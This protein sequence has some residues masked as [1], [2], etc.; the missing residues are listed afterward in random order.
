MLQGG[1]G[2]RTGACG[3]NGL[4]RRESPRTRGGG[5]RKEP[6][7]QPTFLKGLG[8]DYWRSA[9]QGA[10]TASAPRGLPRQTWSTPASGQVRHGEEMAASGPGRAEL[11][12]RAAVG[13]GRGSWGR[14]AGQAG[15]ALLCIGRHRDEQPLPRLQATS[16]VSWSLPRP[17][18]LGVKFKHVQLVVS[19]TLT[20]DTAK[21]RRTGRGRG[22]AV[23]VEITS[24]E[25]QVSAPGTEAGAWSPW[26]KQGWCSGRHAAQGT[27]DSRAPITNTLT[28]QLIY[29]PRLEPR[30]P[31]VHTPELTCVPGGSLLQSYSELPGPRSQA[32]CPQNTN[33]ARFLPPAPAPQAHVGSRN[34]EAEVSGGLTRLSIHGEGHR[35]EE[36][37]SHRGGAAGQ[38]ELGGARQGPA[39]HLEGGGSR[40]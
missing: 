29:Q 36:A 35:D 17:L 25:D 37:E 13:R 31:P 20:P 26:Q 34:R 16:L 40:V 22:R 30:A 10:N 15:R 21:G 27:G 3:P 33:T 5:P 1:R 9:G 38:P 2:A 4:G 32:K 39:L 28:L 11:E 8:G 19:L 23:K 14:M 12:S 24:H 18:R 6:E 7:G